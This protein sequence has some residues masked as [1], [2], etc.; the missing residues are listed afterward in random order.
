MSKVRVACRIPNGISIRLYKTGWDD[1]TGDGV[2]PT[3]PDGPFVRLAGPSS[4]LTGAGATNRLDLEPSITE[5]DADWMNK[6]IE[7]NR[8]KNPF[9]DTGLI[10]I[11]GPVDE[12]S[13]GKPAEG[14][15]AA[16]VASEGMPAEIAPAPAAASPA[17][18]L[19]PVLAGDPESPL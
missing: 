7:Q 6:W 12:P 5:V 1:G 16:S 10:Y 8:G 9:L 11:V 19:A 3:V 15:A 2:K 14:P 18:G 4:R 13:A 17:A